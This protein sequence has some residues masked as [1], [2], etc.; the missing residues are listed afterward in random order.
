MYTL[1]FSYAVHPLCN[2]PGGALAS[3]AAG[4]ESLTLAPTAQAL[5]PTDWQ[6]GT[7]NFTGAAG[8]TTTISFTN[9]S[10]GGCGGV[11]IDNVSVEQSVPTTVDQCKNGGWQS[12]GLFRNQ[13]DCVSFVVSRNPK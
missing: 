6:Q 10:G 5:S 8:P 13:G 4:T 7:L 11:V 1:S 12:F 2:E 9:L 3:A